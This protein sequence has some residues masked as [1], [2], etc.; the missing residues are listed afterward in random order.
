[1]R[2]RSIQFEAA[3]SMFF[4]ALGLALIV[5]ATIPSAIVAR[6][7]DQTTEAD[8]SPLVPI[9]LYLQWYHQFQFAGYYAALEQGYYRDAGLDVSIIEGGPGVETFQ[10][11]AS[12]PG[13]YGT[14][15]GAGVLLQR[16]KGQPLVALAAIFQEN[17]HAYGRLIG[18]IKTGKPGVRIFS[19]RL[20]RSRLAG[21]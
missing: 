12:A 19:A 15:H 5:L 3:S 20:R 16:I 1:M 9:T 7:A 21:H 6:A 2:H 13:R 17:Y 14:A 10:E 11:V 4:A 8:H 18:S